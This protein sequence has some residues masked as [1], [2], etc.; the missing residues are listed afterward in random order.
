VSLTPEQERAVARRDRSLMV[1]AGAGTGKTT[2]LVERFVRAV[3]DD[4]APVEGI[5]AITFTEKAAAEMK[6]RVRRRFLELGRRDEARAAEGAWISTIHG[7]CSRVL[8]AHALS[9]GIDPAFRVIDELE[10]ERVATDAFDAALGTFMGEGEDPERLEMVAAYTPDRLRDMVRTAHAR[11]R[12]RGERR[13]HLEEA[14]PPAVTTQHSDLEAAARTVLAELGGSPSSPSQTT[15]M[16]AVERCLALLGGLPPD[17]LAEP[18]ELDKLSFA[19]RSKSLCSAACDEYRDAVAAYTALCTARREYLD[20]TMLRVLL[21]L[22]GERYEEGKRR[23]S[24]LD[25]EDLELIA[26]DLLAGDDGLREQYAERFVHV[27]VDEF[28]DTNP[29]QNE[30]LELLGRDNL[31]RVGDERQSIYGFRHADVGVFRGHWERAAADGCAESI[32][33]NFRSRGEVL[34]AIDLAF[35]RTWDDFEPLR[36]APGS[37]EA[38]PALDPCVELLVTDRSKKRWDE[39]LGTDDPFGQAMRNATPWRAAEARLLARRIE[40]IAAEGG[41]EWRDVVVLLRAT[42]HMV[43]YERALEERGIPTHVVGGRGYWSQQQVADLRHWLSALAN[44]LDELAVYSVLASPLA[45]LS[46]DAVALIGL[47]AREAK[48]DPWWA[49]REAFGTAVGSA[50]PAGVQHITATMSPQR[51]GPTLAELLPA[52]DRRRVASFVALFE[53]ERRAAPQVS[54]ETLIDRAVTKTGYDT[55]ILSLPAGTRRMAN[56]RKLMR[57]AREFEADEGRDL[58]G[59]IDALAERDVLQT[60]EGEAPL[61]AEALDAVRLMTVHRA[62]GLE[63]PVV[64]LADLGKDGREDDGSLR[65]S[66]DGSLGLR[67]ASIGGGS[68]DSAQLERIKAEQKTADEAEEKRIFYVAVTRAQQH[69]VL[70]GAVDLEQMPEPDELKEPMRW[71]LR[72][73]CPSAATAGDPAGVHEDERE[74]RPVRV[75][76]TRLVPAG[77]D[78][79]LT[80]ADRAPARAEPEP[81]G[82]VRQ[83]ELGLAALPAPRALPVSRLSYTGLEDYRRCSYRFYLEKA[84]RLP[85]VDPPFAAEPLPQRGIGPLLRGTLVHQMLERLDFRRP[86]VPSEADVTAL[87]E[88]HGVTLSAEELADL[89]D[90]VERFT[91]SALRERIARAR[92]VRTELPFAYTLEPPGAGGR[93]VL[94]N[95]VVDVHAAEDGEGLLVVDYKSDPL[96]GRD[97]AELT[98]SNYSTQRL[99]YAL[100]G[101]RAGAARVEVAHCFLEQPDRP[102]AAAYEKADAGGLEAELHGLARGVVEARFEPTAE[103]HAELCATCPGRAALCSWDEEHTLSVRTPA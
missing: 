71:V 16:K 23:R 94:V 69:L 89:R 41:F 1:R 48:R 34:D 86:R 68:V 9:A 75:R 59:F 27:L 44:P 14:Q 103:P 24:G 70:S 36:E 7:F 4:S 39:A 43:F 50:S 42:T 78:A 102:A 53:S 51:D 10:G 22:Y 62:K 66:D 92:R 101:L 26:R 37:R 97:P 32:T 58:R 21:E 80:A 15:A 46:L 57:M 81:A 54:L 55:H 12:S 100:A 64:C 90:M 25:F 17:T 87:G 61:E 29:L 76:Y 31:F 85:P 88:A 82:G 49:L 84:L 30:L 65:I 47:H 67:L 77:A 79:V 95:G 73:F 52:A 56:V 60:R 35:E 5:L 74:G 20:H 18:A 3:V 33:V 40:E 8:R 99:V 98:A 45:G 6:A 93:S 83:P 28:Q 63:F 96:D 13:P 19:G 2:V 91:G 11:L 38:K 72:G